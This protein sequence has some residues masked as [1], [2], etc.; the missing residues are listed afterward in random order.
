[1]RRLRRLAL[2]I[3]VVAAGLT[4]AGCASPQTP[5]P[6][7]ATPSTA[8]SAYPMPDIPP[9]VSVTPDV[10]TKHTEAWRR[11]QSGDIRGS[12][13][14]FTDI[15]KRS[16]GFYPAETAMGFVQL[17]GRQYKNAS[18]RFATATAANDRYVPAW[19][20]QADALLGL[21]RDADA[22]VAME[23]VLAL[24]PRREVVRTRLD[25]VRFRLTQS[26]LEG[27]RKARAA[28]RFDDALQQLQQALRLSP[29]STMILH[30]L[31]L[32]EVAAKRLEE[33][34]THARRTT[35]LEPREADGHALL[36]S[37][38]EARGKYREAA[39]AYARAANLD[40][41][42]EW[43]SR[44][45]DLR[46]KAERAALPAT[47]AQLPTAPSVTRAEVAAFIGIRLDALIDAAPRRMTDIATDIR[48]HWAAPW[49]LPVTRAGVMSIYPNHT[50]Q[51]AATVRR[52]D[53]ATM[54]AA[55]LRLASAGRPAE[56]A[57]WQ[58]ARP[59][60]TDLSAGHVSYP[61]VAL[62]VG[63]GAM[64]ADSSGRFDPN[65]LATGA[66]LDTAVRRVGQLAPR[67]P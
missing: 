10:R 18:A 24:D 4:C 19:I 12:S 49:I 33:A 25:L 5:P 50:F 64:S 51:P 52:G 42:P 6:K 39:A 11:F 16:P 23:K 7:T 36:G 65:R 56:L 30:D 57:R 41:R 54:V 20:G 8:T 44:S 45:A 63:S 35:D 59:R 66:D 22:I 47:F 32:T 1:M 21:N 14:T 38:L 43:R 60:F 29:D 27:G 40:P 48:T 9:G 31:T 46:E 3:A 61:A 62:A 2:A 34:E 53:L 28:G 67:Q 58:A 26:L 17:A 55:L 15:L 37:V 13:S